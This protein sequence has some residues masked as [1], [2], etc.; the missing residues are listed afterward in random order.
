MDCEAR[1]RKYDRVWE[2]LVQHSLTLHRAGIFLCLKHTRH[3]IHTST[4][5]YSQP[6]PHIYSQPFPH[7]VWLR[8]NA[9]VSLT[10][11]AVVET[12]SDFS[13][14][15]LNLN[16]ADSAPQLPTELD[17]IFFADGFSSIGRPTVYTSRHEGTAGA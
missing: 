17:C 13:L 3:N 5:I 7:S 1:W 11:V 16:V 8:L 6:F 10:N 9:L 15:L 14:T 2:P 4:H 12:P